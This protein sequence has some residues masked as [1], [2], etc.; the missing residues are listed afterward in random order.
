MKTFED[1][2]QIVESQNVSNQFIASTT[3]SQIVFLRY[4]SVQGVQQKINSLK[5]LTLGNGTVIV[6]YIIY[7]E[8]NECLQFRVEKFLKTVSG[9]FIWQSEESTVKWIRTINNEYCL[10][11]SF[12]HSLLGQQFQTRLPIIIK[13]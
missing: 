4:A 11:Y 8:L 1:I 10:M 12:E 9:N 5:A 2:I 13:K 6:P 3:E 7:D